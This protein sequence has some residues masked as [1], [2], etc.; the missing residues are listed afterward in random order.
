LKFTI[1]MPM[2]ANARAMSSP[3]IRWRPEVA[4]TLWWS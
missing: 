3:M 4:L 2:I 1:T